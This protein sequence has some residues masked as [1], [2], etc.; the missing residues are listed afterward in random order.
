[1]RHAPQ[2]SGLC[3]LGYGY[4]GTLSPAECLLPEVRASRDVAALFGGSGGGA[5]AHLAAA[6]VACNPREGRIVD[7]SPRGAL[8]ASS[9]VHVRVLRG[10]SW[11]WVRRMQVHT[12]RWR[13]RRRCC[14][15]RARF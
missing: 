10:R 8:G 4:V 2:V 9:A 12:R 6:Y 15:A 1:M 14:P 7:V 13:R 11:S 5:G 3:A